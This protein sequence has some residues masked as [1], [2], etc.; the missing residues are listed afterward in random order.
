MWIKFNL[1]GMKIKLKIE[2]YKPNQT[3]CGEW[4]ET[5]FSFEFQDVIKYSANKAQ[6]LLNSEVDK[7]REYT[8]KLLNGKLDEEVIYKCIEPDFE[9]TF[10]PKYDV[11]N[12][13]DITWVKPGV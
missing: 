7:I 3:I 5:S 2:Q 6:I 9:F 10:S 4:A 1:H 8:E 13:A 12:D 11:R